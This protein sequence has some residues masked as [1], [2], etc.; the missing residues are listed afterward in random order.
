[1][2]CFVS[3][4]CLWQIGLSSSLIWRARIERIKRK[5]SVLI[6][7]RNERTKKDTLDATD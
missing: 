1:M 2:Y 7:E 3:F 4:V 5:N 6:D